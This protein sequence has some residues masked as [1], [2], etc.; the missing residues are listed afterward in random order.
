MMRSVLCFA[1]LSFSAGCGA[2]ETTARLD[3]GSFRDADVVL[4]A[5]GRPD[6]EAGIACRVDGTTYPSGSTGVPD[7]TS[8]NTCACEQGV[9]AAC[10]EL[11]CPEPCPAGFARG[12]ACVSCGPVD[13]CLEVET[14]CFR[15]CS[16]PNDCPE[17]A[18]PFCASNAG[19]C[20]PFPCG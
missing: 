2:T 10:T 17:P 4:D 9:L 1:V 5:G 14:G 6:A 12:T 20:I 16:G 11:A 18:A 13:E 7:P 19:V 3:G 8:C 15:T